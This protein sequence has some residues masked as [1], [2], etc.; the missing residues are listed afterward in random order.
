MKEFESLTQKQFGY[1]LTALVDSTVQH[2]RSGKETLARKLH[3]TTKRVLLIKNPEDFSEPQR[4]ID[5]E[6]LLLIAEALEFT[7]ER[8][9]ICGNTFDSEMM[10]ETAKVVRGIKAQR[11]LDWIN[12]RFQEWIA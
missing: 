6:Q 2:K 9:R 11:E 1:I 5:E 3:Q 4:S 8:R 7:A 10:Q 12:N